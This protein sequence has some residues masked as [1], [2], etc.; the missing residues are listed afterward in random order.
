MELTKYILVQNVKFNYYVLIKSN[1]N[2]NNTINLF[3]F[4]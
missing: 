3:S 2:I 4:I 1:S